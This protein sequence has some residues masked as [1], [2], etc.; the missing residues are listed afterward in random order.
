VL[1]TARA[2][3]TILSLGIYAKIHSILRYLK[4]F[5]IG[6]DA[7]VQTEYLDVL[8]TMK[9]NARGLTKEALGLLIS[10]SWTSNEK[11]S[12]HPMLVEVVAQQFLTFDTR[13]K[14]IN[15]DI[16]I[17]A[18]RD[19]SGWT[20]I[21]LVDEIS[22]LEIKS[23]K[24]SGKGLPIPIE[25]RCEAGLTMTYP[26]AC[27]RSF[28]LFFESVGVQ[29]L[30]EGKVLFR[31][32]LQILASPEME[33]EPVLHKMAETVVLELEFVKRMLGVEGNSVEV[34]SMWYAP[35]MAEL[36]YH[37]F[38]LYSNELLGDKVLA[39]L[40]Q[41]CKTVHVKNLLKLKAGEVVKN[42]FKVTR[43]VVVLNSSRELRVGSLVFIKLWSKDPCPGLPS[44]AVIIECVKKDRF[45][46]I[47]L[48][49]PMTD[50]HLAWARENVGDHTYHGVQPD[51][52]GKAVGCDTCVLS[53]PCL[54]FLCE[55]SE[56]LMTAIFRYLVACKYGEDGGNPNKNLETR[57]IRENKVREV[58]YQYRPTKDEDFSVPSSLREE[59]LRGGIPELDQIL[60]VSPFSSKFKQEHFEELM[61]CQEL[62]NLDISV[63]RDFSF[64][65]GTMN[66]TL[67]PEEVSAI[68]LKYKRKCQPQPGKPTQTCA[69]C[70]CCLEPKSRLRRVHLQCG[71]ALCLECRD[72]MTVSVR[73][74]LDENNAIPLG[75]CVCPICRNGSILE[76]GKYPSLDHFLATEKPEEKGIYKA[77]L[78]C[79]KVFLA[80]H[81]E[82][83]GREAEMPDQCDDCRKPL[84]FKCPVCERCYQHDGG[85]RFMRCCPKGYHGCPNDQGAEC[86]HDGMGC[87]HE[88]WITG[89]QEQHGN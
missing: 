71:H 33:V 58:V 75:L 11:P 35:H 84:F 55:A 13:Y 64:R 78:G 45:K 68:L 47:Y 18:V 49:E 24:N 76:H 88:W 30:I 15:R 42:E 9:T 83:A 14:N 56:E 28:R 19:G 29:T 89:D 67:T 51:I 79:Q 23:T 5:N 20:M 32:L 10:G 50:A 44:V 36:L 3:P 4:D 70:C 25:K 48:D 41:Y 40:F 17:A 60:K 87:G 52:D 63:P 77:C 85:C 53:G 7:T 8:S 2:D 16:V 74:A 31:L 61:Q 39:Q 57:K 72:N 54:E 46:L 26:E 66:I 86:D 59:I 38:T 82:C 27:E 37:F 22:K 81:R 69:D 34:D 12:W 6:D 73:K 21:R 62:N 43:K 1:D 65:S 80:G